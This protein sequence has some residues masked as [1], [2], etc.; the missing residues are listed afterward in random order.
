MNNGDVLDFGDSAASG[1]RTV[2]MRLTGMAG[3][4]RAHGLIVVRQNVYRDESGDGTGD[5]GWLWVCAEPRCFPGEGHDLV[6]RYS[7]A[8][9]DWQASTPDDRTWRIP[10]GD[11]DAAA[12]AAI[13]ILT[14]V[15]GGADTEAPVLRNVPDWVSLVLSGVATSLIIPFVQAITKKSADDA[16]AGL[17]ARLTE[18]RKATAEVGATETTPPAPSTSGHLSITD[19]EVDLQLVVPDPIPPEA[20]RQLAAMDRSELRGR[21]LVWDEGRQEWFRCRRT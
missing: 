15:P 5:L 8:D 17:R 21:T 16:Y 18:R 3:A 19:P 7:E 13:G 4:L 10:A 12:E 1:R 11:D 2:D 6:V 9:G 20:V 14:P